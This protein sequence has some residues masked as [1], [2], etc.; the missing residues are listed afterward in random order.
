MYGL[1][2]L[3][4]ERIV[5][6]IVWALSYGWQVLILTDGPSGC[7]DKKLGLPTIKLSK[8]AFGCSPEVHACGCFAPIKPSCASK[9][10]M[11]ILDPSYTYIGMINLAI[12]VTL[13][14]V[15]Y[16][17]IE[18]HMLMNNLNQTKVDDTPDIS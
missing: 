3:M 13:I 16:K 17:N 4:A 14:K 12:Y 6:I 2:Y 7:L 11:K 15:K 5:Q 8:I 9:I 10:Y 1:D 18:T